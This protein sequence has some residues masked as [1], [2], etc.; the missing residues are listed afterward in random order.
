M[1]TRLI[2]ALV[3]RLA[4]CLGVAAP[5]SIAI[6]EA[7]AAPPASAAGNGLYSV[8]PAHISGN[9]ARPYFNYLVNPSST[10]K[11]AV[12]VTNFTPEAIAFKLF[13][14]DA[15]NTQNGGDFA[16]NSPEAPKLSVGAW[17][18]LSDVG[19]T[20]PAH[21][22]ANVPFT[23]NV[24]AGEAPGDYAGGIVLQTVN[25][26]VE[27]RGALT[28]DVYQNVGTRIY[29]RVAGP[30]HPSLSITH[31]SIDTHGWPGLVGGPVNADVTYTLTNTGN[32]I[33]NPTARLSLSPLV[34]S[35]VN[36]PPKL[37]PSLLPHNSGT[38]TYVVKNQEALL[39]LTANLKV[40]SGAGTTTASTD[41]W[42]IPW[43]LILALILLGLFFWWRR[44][45]RRRRLVAEAAL[46]AAAAGGSE[47]AAAAEV[48]TDAVEAGI[49]PEGTGG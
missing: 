39:R 34:G 4:L 14:T 8:F 47:S 37:F 15:I 10:V 38:V 22:L 29:L 2:G 28:F 7:G 1:K 32:K 23:L 17:V 6:L 24:P 26:T 5:V 3:L 43:L 25:P 44:R 49:T 40:I 46:V 16:Y 31:L 42:V 21:S 41:V 45:R 36:L 12:T 11:D 48:S 20:L 30:L 19:F 27:K 35:T 9:A 18:Q 13:S 33:L